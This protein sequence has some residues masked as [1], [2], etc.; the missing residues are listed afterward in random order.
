MLID[1]VTKKHINQLQDLIYEY[2]GLD[3]NYENLFNTLVYKES[4]KLA[5]R[6]KP[7]HRFFMY[8]W[9]N[10]VLHTSKFIVI[11]L[12]SPIWIIPA[13]LYLKLEESR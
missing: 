1:D 3:S 13:I 4:L 10:R 2:E 9:I 12:T 8:R 6:V 7:I 5:K 11:F